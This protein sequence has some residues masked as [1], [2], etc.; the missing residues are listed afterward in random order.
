MGFNTWNRFKN[1]ISERLINDTATQMKSLGFLDAGYNYINLNDCWLL[2]GRGSDGH[3]V[4]DPMKFPS[5]P[6]N[7]TTF[8]SRRD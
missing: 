3:L 1:N 6:F 8:P 2:K 4:P 5:M 7:H